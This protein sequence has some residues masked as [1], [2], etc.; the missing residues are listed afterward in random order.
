MELG[1][2]RS[3]RFNSSGAFGRLVMSFNEKAM[4]ATLVPTST[5]AA[6][7]TKEPIISTDFIILIKLC[8]SL[9]QTVSIIILNSI[10]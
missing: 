9:S 2:S 3:M 4:T 10:V 5:Y 6:E 8:I 1:E 7:E